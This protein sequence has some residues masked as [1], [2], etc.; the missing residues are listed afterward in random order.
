VA[1]GSAIMS[2]SVE[3]Y[4]LLKLAGKGVG[5]DALRRQLSARFRAKRARAAAV[6]RAIS[7]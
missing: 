5:L 7:A 1:L 6:E 4:L 3:G 2:N